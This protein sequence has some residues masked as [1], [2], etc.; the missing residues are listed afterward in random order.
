MKINE[1][2][3]MSSIQAYRNGAPSKSAAAG[4]SGKSAMKDNVNISA[5]AKELL[6][7]QRTTASQPS[8]RV[9]QLKQSVQS[10][11]YQVK[12]ELLAEKLLPYLK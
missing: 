1:T 4:Q 2:G 11:T 5:E 6:E 8:E 10:G 12:A 3:R 9:E 7:A